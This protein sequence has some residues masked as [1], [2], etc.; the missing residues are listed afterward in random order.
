MI[1][2]EA[3]LP[4]IILSF[5]FLL[6][7]CLTTP[8]LNKKEQQDIQ[9]MDGY[10]FYYTHK[11]EDLQDLLENGLNDYSS[12]IAI[13]ECNNLPEYEAC[14]DMVH[15]GFREGF[16]DFLKSHKAKT[17]FEGGFHIENGRITD[18]NNVT[19]NEAGQKK[20]ADLS[21]DLRHRIIKVTYECSNTP[22]EG[23]RLLGLDVE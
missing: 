21:R 18:P 17:L 7:G 3:R 14:R 9:T 2:S 4:P 20:K 6:A 13:K 23:R 15:C 1:H 8:A 11:K 16:V 12:M 5:M 19:Q 22:E 10:T